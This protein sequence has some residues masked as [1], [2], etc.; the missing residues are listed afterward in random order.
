M[1]EK[2]IY[3][4]LNQHLK[5]VQ[6]NYPIENIFGIFVIEI[7]EDINDIESEAC[8]IP[9]FEDVCTSTK[10]I[11]G[12]FL[13]GHIHI[14]DIRTAYEASKC[15][16][17]ET[18][19]A[20]YTD[21]III[22]PQYQYIYQKILKYNR[23]NIR[24]GMI[25]GCPSEQLKL[26]LMKICCQV[27]QNNSPGIIFLKQ[28]TDAEKLALD[29]IIKTIGDEGILSQSKVASLVGISRLTMSNLIMKMKFY[30]VAEVTYIGNKGTYIKFIDDLALNIKYERIN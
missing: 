25:E 17:P 23:E 18:I 6:Q 4:K 28:L 8:I 7:D 9:L 15:G 22:N 16:H 26:G 29:G 3:W 21:Y 13:N 12:S 20:L 10:E 1:N 5:I 2:E 27:W 30:K 24:N 19:N 14:L 11:K